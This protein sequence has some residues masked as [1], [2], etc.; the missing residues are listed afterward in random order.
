MP[1]DPDGLKDVIEALE[2]AEEAMDK[3]VAA[4]VASLGPY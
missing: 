4:L 3:A 1:L 2:R